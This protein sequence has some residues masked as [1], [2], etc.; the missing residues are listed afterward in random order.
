M[1]KKTV[2]FLVYSFCGVMV[3]C[4]A[5]FIVLIG[6][7]SKKTQG[8]VEEVSE[9]YMLEVSEQVQQKF[10]S[11]MSL[12]MMQV[13]GI[14]KRTPPDTVEYGKKMLDELRLS[15]EIRR[16]TYLGAYMEDGTLQTIYGEQMEL[17]DEESFENSLLQNGKVIE[18]GMG[19]S[20]QE[21]LLLGVEAFYPMD[22]GKNSRALVAGVP[23]KY[24]DSVLFLDEAG[25]NV[26]CNII[27]RNGSYVINNS[28]KSNDNYF[29][30]IQESIDTYQ[31]QDPNGY[32]MKLQKAMAEK[33]EYSTFIQMDGEPQHIFCAPL[34]G[35]DTWYLIAV[36]PN[37]ILEEPLTKLD[38]VRIKAIVGCVSII[39]VTMLIILVQ[40]A[41]LAQRQRQELDKA[42]KDAIRANNAKSE[43][44]SSMS[45]DIRTPMN[46]IIG[47]TDIALKNKHDEARVE[48]CLRNV[49]LSSKHLL[50]LINDV[51]DMSKIESG[52]MTLNM[53]PLS[54][55]DMVDDL[56]N[57]MQPQIR[58]RNQNFDVFIKNIETEIVYSD[59]VRL[60]QVLLNFL[61]NAV[62]FTPQEGSIH[63]LMYQEP[64]P[65]GDE[66]VRNHF[67][68]QDTGIGMSKEFQAKIFNTFTREESEEVQKITGT[69]LG[70]SI[71]KN[72]VDLM[73]GTI[74]LESELGKGSKFHVI[75]DMEKGEAQEEMTLP[76]WN[77]LVVDDN[78]LLCTSA[79]ANLEELGI[80]AEWA[81]DGATAVKMVEER[82]ERNEDYRFA[83]IDWK[84]P[85]M[86]GVETIQKIR[87]SVGEK[88]PIFLISAYNWGDI[89]DAAKTAGVEGFIAKPLF[90][91]TL[92]ASLSRYTEQGSHKPRASQTRK[93]V[94]FTGKRLLIAE[95]VE[96]NWIVAREA[97]QEFGFELEHA[98]NG[99][100][101]VEMFEQSQVGY[102][103]GILMDIRMPVMN[104]YDATWAIRALEREDNEVPIIAMTAD[105]FSDDVQYCL[106]CGMNAHVAKPLD[107][108]ELVRTIQTYVCDDKENSM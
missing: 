73:G 88:V 64:S 10:D 31:G 18:R 83:L 69:G 15:T 108:R 90:K 32:V 61:S 102:Y 25:G 58:E 35:N 46:A 47:M 91:S 42:R 97:L 9:I 76:G 8:T 52:K 34:L 94:D 74:E 66:W 5:L 56:V 3:V 11:I 82:H 45:H 6:F 87:A 86:D 27:A 21:M 106:S 4:I 36:M 51:L 96:V 24:L 81:T 54:L 77:V 17:L 33:K 1:D 50:G 49:Q 29:E 99:K 103:D 71:S 101:C 7:M 67:I 105:A 107:I 41:R 23:I 62:K 30:N 89:E 63:V 37:G 104:G 53:A 26:S 12:R 20:G 92:Y 57:I 43:F 78:E 60:N 65:R 2:R 80:H 55:R 59:S 85:G 72:I 70:M 68:V 79:A 13:Q 28:D 14:V 38:N 19:S 93:K 75:L 39:T 44:L 98:V 40:Y 100:E 22:N 16:F 48:D 95:D 84:M